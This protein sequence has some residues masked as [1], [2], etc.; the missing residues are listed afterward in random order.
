MDLI[1]IEGLGTLYQKTIL[2]GRVAQILIYPRLSP[3]LADV[4][5]YLFDPIPIIP[6]RIKSLSASSTIFT[7]EA[8]NPHTRLSSG[9]G[10]DTN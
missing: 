7:L 5:L 4:G 6:P 10:S 1:P 8:H 3:R 2:L 9:H